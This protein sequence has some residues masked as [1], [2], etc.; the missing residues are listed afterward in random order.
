MYE[1]AG[2]RISRD[3][4]VCDSGEM[5]KNAP[6]RSQAPRASDPYW[7]RWRD[8]DC[9]CCSL[10]LLVGE[11]MERKGTS[12]LNVQRRPRGSIRLGW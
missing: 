1:S 3:L 6:S 9:S 10:V 5:Q 4:D 12:N 7:H 11:Q 8:L 2:L